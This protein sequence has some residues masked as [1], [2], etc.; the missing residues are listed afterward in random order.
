MSPLGQVI[1]SRRTNGAPF[2]RLLRHAGDTEDVFSASTP[3][4][5]MSPLAIEPATLGFQA[6]HLDSCLAALK[7]HSKSCHKNT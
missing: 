2:S 1:V 5:P 4:V 7:S 3:G 6:G